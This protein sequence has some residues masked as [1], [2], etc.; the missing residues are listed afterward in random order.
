[1]KSD[2]HDVGVVVKEEIVDKAKGP[3]MFHVVIHVDV[4]EKRSSALPVEYH[5]P[6][7]IAEGLTQC[8]SQCCTL[9]HVDQIDE[10]VDDDHELGTCEG[11]N[12]ATNVGYRVAHHLAMMMISMTAWMMVCMNE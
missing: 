9:G 5:D 12:D 10:G 7:G 8:F 6:D 4:G 1:M 3:L 11:M 2:V